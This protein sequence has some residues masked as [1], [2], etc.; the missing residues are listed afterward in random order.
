MVTTGVYVCVLHIIP[1]F[2]PVDIQHNHRFRFLNPRLEKIHVVWSE[3]S[4]MVTR[5]SCT[6]PHRGGLRFGTEDNVVPSRRFRVD[7]LKGLKLSTPVG[8]KLITFGAPTA[9]G[10]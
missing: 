6:T 5:Y 3:C 8:A 4:T 10:Y 9:D 2:V 7:D 1:L